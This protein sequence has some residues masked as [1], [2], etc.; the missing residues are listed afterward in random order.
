V[1]VDFLRLSDGIVDDPEYN[2]DNEVHG[3]VATGD[4]LWIAGEFGAAPLDDSFLDFFE[5][6]GVVR[7]FMPSSG[8]P[9]DRFVQIDY[10]GGD[11]TLYFGNGE[12]FRFNVFNVERLKLELSVDSGQTWV[13][14]DRS[15]DATTLDK[16]AVLIDR[17]G[18]HCFIRATDL[19][20][21]C[22]ASISDEFAIVPSAGGRTLTWLT[23]YR[24]GDLPEPFLPQYHGFQFGNT[25]AE[26]WPDAYWQ[27]LED[28]YNAEGYNTFFIRQF[29]KSRQFSPNYFQTCRALGE[30]Q[31]FPYGS[32]TGDIGSAGLNL[33]RSYQRE[34]GG[35]CTGFSN[36][37]ALFFTAGLWFNADLYPQYIGQP[38]SSI[39]LDDFSRDFIGGWW[40]W[41]LNDLDDDW[42][43]DHEN[44]TP[45]ETIAWFESAFTG[46][47]LDNIGPLVIRDLEPDGDF[48]A[49]HSV[50]PYRLESQSASPD[51]VYLYVYDNNFPLDTTRRIIVD[52]VANTWEYPEL[53]AKK[54]GNY[55]GSTG[56][57][58]GVPRGILV[59]D[60][61]FLREWRNNSVALNNSHKVRLF[62]SGSADA[63]LISAAGDTI[64]NLAG[65]D[66]AT[67]SLIGKPIYVLNPYQIQDRPYGYRVVPEQ[68]A[69]IELFGFEDTLLTVNYSDDS[70]AYCLDRTDAAPGQTDLLSIDSSMTVCNPDAIPKTISLMAIRTFA[71]NEKTY[72][73]EDILI[74]AD[75]TA[76]VQLHEDGKLSIANSGGDKMGR[77]RIRIVDNGGADEVTSDNLFLPANSMVQV[78]PD[79]ANLQVSEVM[80]FV[81]TGRDGTFDD[82]TMLAVVTDVDDDDTSVLPTT[83]ALEQNYPNPFN[84][85]TTIRFMLPKAS[86]VSLTVVNLLGQ[87]VT[88]LVDSRL[89]AGEHEVVWHGRDSNNKP[90][91]S[92][93]YLY[94]LQAES[95]SDTKKML[96]LK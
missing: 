20:Y 73:L 36:A 88:T 84:P 45:K 34:W 79:F 3:F 74:D 49:G 69:N 81:D 43:D 94:R 64:G 54:G 48:I 89:A 65:D 63:R 77:L 44:M 61:D 86:D 93:V 82:T 50:M 8:I 10:P 68:T 55:R 40:L 14:I 83:F 32:I 80:L 38:V 17:T 19:D 62:V 12:V 16:I 27:G 15:I 52:T 92:G 72:G 9:G 85:S 31:C 21:P 25:K 7:Y 87:T 33:L 23:R 24:D 47:V 46:G 5:A 28:R 2:L 90:V 66:F 11:D 71:D 30:D 37:A 67:D 56:F 39:T 1:F 53:D 91:A 76:D 78:A 29:E 13:D 4:T 6:S 26:M 35:Y 60:P 57:F 58:P 59:Q 70:L 95:Y 42:T 41:Q 18:D 51:T 96:L 22:V 75:D